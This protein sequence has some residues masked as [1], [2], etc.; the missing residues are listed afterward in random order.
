MSIRIGNKAKQFAPLGDKTVKQLEDTV[1]HQ[2]NMITEMMS[3]FTAIAGASTNPFTLP[4]SIA[5]TPL[6]A[7]SSAKLIPENTKLKISAGKNN[8]QSKKTYIE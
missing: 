3:L 1:K 8:I 2:G 5:L 7:S 4:I 6:I